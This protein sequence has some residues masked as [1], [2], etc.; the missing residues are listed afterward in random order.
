[1]EFLWKFMSFKEKSVILLSL[2]LTDENKKIV[3][4]AE[5]VCLG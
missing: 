4:R 3:V 1:M 2:S 5:G